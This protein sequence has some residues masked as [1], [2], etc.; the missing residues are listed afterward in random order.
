MNNIVSWMSPIIRPFNI[1]FTIIWCIGIIQPT[2]SLKGL[3]VFIFYGV[4][5]YLILNLII[6]SGTKYKIEFELDGVII[7][8][9][10][11]RIV[12]SSNKI[13]YKNLSN[14]NIVH[15]TSE[16]QGWGFTG[17]FFPFKT[18]KTIKLIYNN[19]EKTIGLAKKFVDFDLVFN[20]L[21]KRTK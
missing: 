18:P 5:I 2:I 17:M 1:I 9:I 13:F 19:K 7:Q 3:N 16:K 8:H 21:K 11:F 4:T 20:E 14:I 10:V 12:I 6:K 15:N